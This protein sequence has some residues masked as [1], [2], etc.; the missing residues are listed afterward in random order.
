MQLLHFLGLLVVDTYRGDLSGFYSAEEHFNPV[1][2]LITY[3]SPI[4][5]LLT[6]HLSRLVSFLVWGVSMNTLVIRPVGMNDMKT[7][8][9]WQPPPVTCSFFDL[10]RTRS[11]ITDMHK[12]LHGIKPVGLGSSFRDLDR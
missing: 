12:Q 2:L 11:I 1:S 4:I 5:I 9:F 7:S 10:R 6:I 3:L 8:R